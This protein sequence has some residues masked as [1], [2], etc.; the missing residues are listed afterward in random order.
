MLG[1]IDRGAGLSWTEPTLTLDE[2][3]DPVAAKTTILVAHDI[4]PSLTR[5]IRTILTRIFMIQFLDRG[6]FEEQFG[7]R[8]SARISAR[9]QCA[10]PRSPSRR[11]RPH[12][13]IPSTSSTSSGTSSVSS[14]NVLRIVAH[15]RC[16]SRLRSTAFDRLP[17]VLKVACR[18][19]L[20]SCPQQATVSGI[21]HLPLS[22]VARFPCHSSI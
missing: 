18:G 20:A 21:W 3:R 5:S 11:A 1:S 16:S 13:S 22:C 10:L 14:F 15:S 2:I 4:L 6:W 8:R 12:F 9:S 19:T 17:S 7:P